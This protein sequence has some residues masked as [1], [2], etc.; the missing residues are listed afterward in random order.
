MTRPELDGVLRLVPPV[1]F[2]P[3]IAA[4]SMI[5]VTLD[6]AGVGVGGLGIVSRNPDVAVAVPAVIAVMPGPAWV[7]AWHGWNDFNGARWGWSDANN[8]LG[9]CN[10]CNK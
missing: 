2:D 3:D 4:T 7:L 9:L 1:A 10:A 5:P 6:P 8:D